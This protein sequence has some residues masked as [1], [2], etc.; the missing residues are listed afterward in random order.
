MVSKF[1]QKSL[2]AAKN[3]D[4]LKR[5]TVMEEKSY[6][7]LDA[8]LNL[9]PNLTGYN[10]LYVPPVTETSREYDL[11]SNQPSQP[12]DHYGLL[13]DSNRPF[14]HFKAQEGLP[15]ITNKL[16]DSKMP[17]ENTFESVYRPV[18]QVA[19]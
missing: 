16:Y 12:I 3:V 8:P 5:L 6:K 14:K 11:I 17:E 1:E 19:N 7:Y 2:E 4:T 15:E 9:K 13:S 18:T 10:M